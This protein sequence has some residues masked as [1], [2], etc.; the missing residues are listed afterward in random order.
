MDRLSGARHCMS[1]GRSNLSGGRGAVRCYCCPDIKLHEVAACRWRTDATRGGYTSNRIV[2]GALGRQHADTPTKLVPSTFG[3]KAADGITQVRKLV[4]LGSIELLLRRE[5]T[6][7][8]DVEAVGQLD[9]A[10]G[11]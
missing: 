3:Q 11:S 5:C 9:D 8:T 10:A 6:P 1:L 7:Q 2:N 4:I